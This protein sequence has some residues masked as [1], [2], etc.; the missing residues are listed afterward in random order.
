[1]NK[2]LYVV[3]ALLLAPAVHAQSRVGTTAAPFLTL[4]TGARTNSLGHAAVSTAVGAE[5]LFWNPGLIAVPG[6][7]HTGGL[8]FTSHPLFA[9]IQYTA[10]GLTIPMGANGVLGASV[11][12]VDYGR[13]DVTSE[14][15]A[16]DGRTGETFAPSDLML[17]LSYAQPLT[18][19]FSFGATVKYVDQRIRDMRASAFA[20]DLGFVLVTDYLNNARLAASIQNFGTKL[21]FRGVNGRVFVAPD[22]TNRGGN[23]RVPAEYTTTEWDLPLSFRLG[24]AVPVFVSDFASLTLM[25]DVQQTNDFG[26]NMDTGAEVRFNV[27]GAALAFRGGYKDLGPPTDAVDGHWTY[28]SGLDLNLRSFRLGVDIGVMTRPY[29]GLSRMLDLRLHF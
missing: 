6:Q 19:A 8:L 24:A 14:L 18:N 16:G 9:D 5:A 27:G 23:D 1:M 26:L 29:L 7:S 11:A 28:G 2:I 20:V 13:M 21:Q 17:G 4:G 15:L 22:P 25:S 10:F 12:S 3:L